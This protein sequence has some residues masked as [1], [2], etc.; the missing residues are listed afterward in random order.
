[1]L[2][3][4]HIVL[5]GVEPNDLE[6]LYAWENHEDVWFS[7]SITRPLSKQTLKWYIDSVNDIYT[8]KQ[9]RLVIECNQIAVGCIDL[10]DFEPLH[11][12]AGVGIMIDI[13]HQKR[14]YANQALIALKKYAFTQ[15]GLHQLYCNIAQSN[16]K[17]IALFSKA[18]FAH[19][20]T[21]KDWLR[22]NKSWQDE[23]MFQCF[24]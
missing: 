14:G 16:Q 19:T 17:S 24:S 12:R 6:L 18:G 3:E 8:D 20:A 11:Q 2:K 9:V 13:N 5:R 22:I 23:L 10:F 7:S 4:N 1:M 15:L 21:K